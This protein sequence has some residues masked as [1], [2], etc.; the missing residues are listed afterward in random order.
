VRLALVG[1]LFAAACALWPAPARAGYRYGGYTPVH[2]HAGER[3]VL[4]AP[5]CGLALRRWQDHDAT[6]VDVSNANA[7]AW[8]QAGWWLG[9]SGSGRLFTSPVG[10]AEYRL[11]DATYRWQPLGP[12]PPGA[13][14]AVWR[15]G[16]TVRDG[17]GHTLSLYRIAASYVAGPV[18]TFPYPAPVG[19]NAG[20]AESYSTGTALEPIGPASYRAL[21][22]YDRRRWRLWTPAVDSASATVGAGDRLRL[23]RRWHAWQV[24][25]HLRLA[26]PPHSPLPPLSPVR[27]ATPSPSPSPPVRAAL[28]PAWTVTAGTWRLFAPAALAPPAGAAHV[29][30]LGA[31]ARGRLVGTAVDAAGRLVLWRWRVGSS[32]PGAPAVWPLG[33]VRARLG[34]GDAGGWVALR[35]GAAAYAGGRAIA[36]LPPGRGR[37]V[38]VDLGPGGTVAA[39]AGG[40]ADTVAVVRAGR[41]T[42]ELWRLTKSGVRRVARAPLPAGVA[43]PDALAYVGRGRYFADQP[44]GRDAGYASVV[45]MATARGGA[46]RVVGRWRQSAATLAAAGGRVLAAG[47]DRARGAAVFTVAR[48]RWRRPA[49]FAQGGVWGVAAAAAADGSLWL[50]AERLGGAV[51]AGVPADGAAVSLRLPPLWRDEDPPRARGAAGAPGRPVVAA[52]PYELHLAAGPGWVAAAPLDVP[53]VYVARSPFRSAAPSAPAPAGRSP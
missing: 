37:V 46:L 39:V 28:V 16:A 32:H 27:L 24:S 38:L 6:Y 47:G 35:D 50:G 22:L 43:V 4:S 41:R 7:T 21:S 14:Y 8:G 3:A 48:G 13:R 52:A 31:D 11:P 23:D 26:A 15:T 33:D 5:R 20:L 17:A 29:G 36:W 51:V 2:D 40:A 53:V 12:P 42:L 49:A 25:G 1:P 45:E 18:A 44:D 10:Y 34:L 19:D 30:A 9:T